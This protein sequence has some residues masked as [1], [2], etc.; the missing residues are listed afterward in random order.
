MTVMQALADRIG[1]QYDDLFI[2]SCDDW[3]IPYLADLVGTSHLAGDPWTL[4]A[5]VAREI[6]RLDAALLSSST[7]KLGANYHLLPAPEDLRDAAD[8]RP[9]VIS[10]L[11]GVACSHYDFVVLDMP[12]N[13]DSLSVAAL[14]R[15]W[16]IYPVLQA[17]LPDLRH[18]ARLYTAFRSLGYA[19]DKVEFILNRFQKN[20]DIGLAELKRSLGPVKVQTVPNDWQDV[21][22]SIA[23]GAP[24]V[25]DSRGSGVARHLLDLANSISPQQPE[26]HRGLLDKLLFR[27]A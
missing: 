19:E 4:R 20:Q 14:D 12:R 13:L 23:S 18:A 24:L 21:H 25:R 9:E 6:R 22:A 7:V 27:K 26:A 10:A 3:L 8:I 5:D 1:A 15:T 16:R 11:L 17:N 2:E